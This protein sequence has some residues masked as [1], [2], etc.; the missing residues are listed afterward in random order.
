MSEPVRT[1][2]VPLQEPWTA[3]TSNPQAVSHLFGEVVPDLTDVELA[4]F[5]VDKGATFT[6]VAVRLREWP[7]RA[8]RRWALQGHDEVELELSA[9]AHAGISLRA[10]P[11]PHVVRFDF[12]PLV[13]VGPPGAFVEVTGPRLSLRFVGA[14][15]HVAGLRGCRRGVHDAYGWLRDRGLK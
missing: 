10:G 12:T 11:G 7:V 8:P 1:D 3:W 5:D 13:K 15:L 4:W 2:P 6:R 14:Y 9:C